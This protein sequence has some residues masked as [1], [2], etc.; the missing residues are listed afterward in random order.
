MLNQQAMRSNET[1]VRAV[2]ADEIT[3][4]QKD[5][6]V[7]L[8]GFLSCELVKRLHYTA[9]RRMGD[10]GDS[11][12]LSVSTVEFCNAVAGA[13]LTDPL[14]RPLVSQVGKAAKSLMSRG[15]G[16][17]V[18]YTSD[19]FVAK[20]PATKKYKH[21]GNGR[22][23]FHQDFAAWCI[24][25]SGGMTFWVALTDLT[26]AWGHHVFRKWLPPA[27]CVG[28]LWGLRER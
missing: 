18:R 6:W 28:T 27:G 4:F 16:I 22:T 9:Q 21:A 10:D 25:R 11:N 1:L 24:D 19:S 14:L 23:G 2:T 26:P 7:K 8:E 3:Q 5:G 20:L 17:E 15:A 13:A 12:A